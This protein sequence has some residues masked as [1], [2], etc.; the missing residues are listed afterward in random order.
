MAR[1]PGTPDR[2]PHSAGVRV[3]RCRQRPHPSHADACGWAS[4]MGSWVVGTCGSSKKEGLPCNAPPPPGNAV[5]R[6]NA[7]S[8]APMLGKEGDRKDAS[9]RCQSHK[10]ARR[11]SR[12]SQFAFSWALYLNVWVQQFEAVVVASSPL[13]KI[14]KSLCAQTCAHVSMLLNLSICY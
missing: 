2:P 13:L 10:Y 4:S 3:G 6:R 1:S 7:K 5:E 9:A 8:P 11:E 12:V 14:Y